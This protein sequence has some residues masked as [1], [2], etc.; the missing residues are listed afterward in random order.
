KNHLIGREF[1]SVEIFHDNIV[2]YPTVK[3]FKE[4]IRNKKIIDI[5]TRGKWIVFDL[6]KDY[7]LVH[8]RMEGK[9]FYRTSKDIREKH[10]HVIFTL[11]TK[12]QLRYHDVRKF[13]KMILISKEEAQSHK[14]F[15]ELGLEFWDS[16]L[17]DSYLKEHYRSKSLPIKST[18]LDQSIITGIGNIYADEILYLSH[19]SP[20]LPT[21]RLTKK[22][23]NDIILYTR[24]VLNEAIEAG[25]TTIRS[26]TSEEGVHGL[27]Q[28]QLKV[29]GKKGEPCPTCGEKILKIQIGGRGTYYCP[30]CQKNR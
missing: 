21:N 30:K 2:S 11:D 27:F 9:F 7:L 20:L 6:G 14:P 5:T 15:S 22:N 13:G 8:L 24:E 17:T 4:N 19:I 23:R 28:Q 26:Y 1:K 10:E 18:L 3:E 29:H 16:E 25:G 12:E